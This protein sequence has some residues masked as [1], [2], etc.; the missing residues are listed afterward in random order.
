MSKKYALKLLHLHPK[1]FCRF[2]G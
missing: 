1:E 2:W